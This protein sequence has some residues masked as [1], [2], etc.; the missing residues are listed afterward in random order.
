MKENYSHPVQLHRMTIVLL[1]RQN[2]YTKE[3]GC[4][5]MNDSNYVLLGNFASLEAEVIESLLRQMDIPVLRQ[6]PDGGGYMKIYTGMSMTGVSLYV[7]EP[8]LAR[9][10]QAVA[11]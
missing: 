8:D 7:P 10:R 11:D 3:R 1:Y 4:R 9:A 6:Y 2:S 5:E